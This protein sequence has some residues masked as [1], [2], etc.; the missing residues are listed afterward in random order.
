MNNLPPILDKIALAKFLA[1]LLYRAES[2]ILKDIDRRPETLPPPEDFKYVG[3]KKLWITE[4]VVDWLPPGI[5]AAIRRAVKIP[6][7]QPPKLLSLADELELAG[8][9]S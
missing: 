8:R 2:T 4:K 6:T 9:T 1:P 5:A 3:A 7:I